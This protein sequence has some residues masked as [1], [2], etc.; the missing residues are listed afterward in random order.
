MVWENKKLGRFRYYLGGFNIMAVHS[1][2]VKKIISRVRQAFPDAPETYIM[3]LINEAIVE[4]GKYG[5]KIEYAKATTVADQQ[6]YTL[7]DSNAG[8]EI[9][10]VF[11]VDFMDSSGDYVKI[12]RLV[13]NEIPTMDID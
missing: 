2:T 10:K 6:W 12:P 13:N 9:N 1:L 8:V 4:L 5:T 3:N 7:S 11:R